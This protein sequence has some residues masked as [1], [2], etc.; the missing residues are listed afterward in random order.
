MAKGHIACSRR[1]SLRA[2]QPFPPLQPSLVSI[3]LTVVAVIAADG[4]LN[5][6]GAVTFPA[7]CER[8]HSMAGMEVHR[9]ACRQGSSFLLHVPS[10]RLADEVPEFDFCHIRTAVSYQLSVVSR[11]C[12]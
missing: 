6:T 7:A 8:E 5:Q 10:D 4:R 1:A 3:R 2:F 9:R 12:R 11:Q